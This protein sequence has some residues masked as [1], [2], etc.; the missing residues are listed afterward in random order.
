MS[1]A[2]KTKTKKRRRDAQELVAKKKAKKNVTKQLEQ[3]IQASGVKPKPKKKRVKKAS[4]EKVED[5]SATTPKKLVVA[6]SQSQIQNADSNKLEHNA[7]SADKKSS[8]AQKNVEPVADSTTNGI[9]QTGK[10]R[11]KRGKKAKAKRANLT[12]EE[13][14]R[15]TNQKR[16][17]KLVR[18]LMSKGT[19]KKDIRKAKIQFRFVNTVLCSN[20]ALDDCMLMVQ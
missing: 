13:Q 7:R 18:K 15:V 11:A 3:E 17:Q 16:M 20:T 1:S 6:A 4:S 19:S 5:S 8:A 10:K 12:H 9:R 14:T 2:K